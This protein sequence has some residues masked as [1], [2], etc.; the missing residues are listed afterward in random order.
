MVSCRRNGRNQRVGGIHVGTAALTVECVR[1]KPY[2]RSKSRHSQQNGGFCFLNLRHSKVEVSLGEYIEIVTSRDGVRRDGSF[3]HKRMPDESPAD[4]ESPIPFKILVVDDDIDD[5]HDEISKLPGMLCAAGYEVEKTPDGVRAY[6]LVLDYKPDLVVLDIQ[7]KNQP[8][9][10]FEICKAIR[11]NEDIKI[12]IILITA[13]MKE[14]E[15]VLRGFEAGADDYVTRHRDNREIMARIR[16]NLPP[17]VTDYN[18]DLRIDKVTRRVCVKRGG[19]WQEVHLMRLEFNLFDVLTMNAGQVVLI[20]T[21]KDQVWG[22]AVSD[23]VL[24]VY[25]RRLQKKLEPVPVEPVYIESVD[26]IG[27]RIHREVNSPQWRVPRK[28]DGL[29]SSTMRADASAAF[30]TE[31]SILFSESVR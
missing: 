11:Q 22:K 29:T 18:D 17:E 3:N 15:Y 23:D 10:G 6:D 25:I 14:S 20:T 5:K 27:F 30:P 8:V 31:L 9:D 26:R 28:K 1:T 4:K 16:A 13:T 12:P 19:T 2:G 21:L 7:F 24:A